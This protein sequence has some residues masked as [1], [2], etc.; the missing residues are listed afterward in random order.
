MAFLEHPEVQILKMLPLGAA[1]DWLLAWHNSTDVQIRAVDQVR[2]ILNAPL[3]LGWTF[4][5]YIMTL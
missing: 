5:T 1:L 2:R 4:K 3:D